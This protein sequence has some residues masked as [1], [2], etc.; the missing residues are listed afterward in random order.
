MVADGLNREQFHYGGMQLL[1]RGRAEPLLHLFMT[2]QTS[3]LEHRL[4]TRKDDEVGYAAD[5]KAGRELWVGLCVNLQNQSL[6]GHIGGGAGDLRGGCLARTAPVG[7]EIDQ[8]RHGGAL[9]HLFKE[10]GIDPKRLG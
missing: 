7:P 9:N 2:H 6:T 8:N 4:S 10:G 5:L 1:L 3:L